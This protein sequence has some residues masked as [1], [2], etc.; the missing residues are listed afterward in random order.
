M[1]AG[2]PDHMTIQA[3]AALNSAD[4]VFIPD[5]GAEKEELRRL[6]YEICARFMTRKAPR[7]V[8]YEA[9]R[10]QSGPDGYR[11]VVDDWHYRIAEQ[12]AALLRNELGDDD[13]GAFLAW[14]DPSL[15]DSTI[16]II[17]AV[18]AR[19]GLALD[20]EVIP[21]I[22][23]VQALAA[24]HRIALNHIGAPV[25]ITTGRRLASE[26][27]LGPD[28]VVVMLDGEQAFAQLSRDD[29]MIYWGAYRG[30]ADEIL[31]AGPLTEVADEIQRVR[32]AARREK[33][34][35]M[36]TYLLRRRDDA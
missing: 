32:A 24:R 25:H 35:I 7:F 3:V 19:H 6:R 9:L 21:G 15:Y 12:Y 26:A 23:S 22:T 31:I 11:Q 20:H 8:E 36:D 34:W 4:V 29:L 30:T 14:G 28:S 33:G 17:E 18:R 1:G 27:P 16:R 2:D 10:R 13:V 5:K